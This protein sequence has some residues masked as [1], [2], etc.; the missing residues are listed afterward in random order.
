LS[1]LRALAV[2]VGVCIAIAMIACGNGN[3]NPTGGGGGTGGTCNGTAKVSGL[4]PV[5]VPIAA[6]DNLVFVPAS[7]TATV[8]EVVQFKN[9]GSVPHTVTFQDN[10]D[11]C[12][13]D[14]SLN[15]G[16]TWEVK[17]SAAG[18]YNYICTIHAPNMKG[19]ITVSGSAAPAGS[20]SG[21]P[22][23]SAGA[24]PSASATPSPAT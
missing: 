20:P 16:A 18:T 6:T 10:N 11:G 13:T 14:D 21:S 2:G 12:L 7:S 19:E 5:A 15:P 24:S 4:G 23:A 9:T 17:F 8:G 1:H 3:P 22:S